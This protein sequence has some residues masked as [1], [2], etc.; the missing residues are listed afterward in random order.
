M[1][2]VKGVGRTM[3]V[4]LAIQPPVASHL[5]QRDKLARGITMSIRSFPGTQEA[6]QGQFA[7]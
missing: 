1:Y 3:R 7:V 4:L 5:L 6:R 2:H